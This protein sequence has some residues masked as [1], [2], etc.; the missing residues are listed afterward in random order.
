MAS[1][2]I[3]LCPPAHI[4]RSTFWPLTLTCPWMTICLACLA[5]LANKDLQMA[6]S[7]RLSRGAY[8]IC[9]YGTGTLFCVDM[10]P[11]TLSF[12]GAVSFPEPRPAA[13][14]EPSCSAKYL[15]FI[16]ITEF[17]RVVNILAHCPSRTCSPWYARVA[18]FA[19]HF[20]WKYV[21]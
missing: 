8:V 2:Y 18:A 5:L 19:D 7:S 1:V 3:S 20:C 17:S 15:A 21:W 10:L 13:C 4:L 14:S 11:F 12:V 16:G 6:M 9:I